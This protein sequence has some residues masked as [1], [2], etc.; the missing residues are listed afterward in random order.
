[1]RGAGLVLAI[2]AI[3]SISLLSACR[4][5]TSPNQNDAANWSEK[6][7][8]TSPNG[9]FDAILMVHL[10]GPPAGG[11]SD[12]NV[13]IVQRGASVG[14][15]EGRE[16]FSADPMT[17]GQLVWKRDHVLEIHYDLAQIHRFRNLWG[18]HE[19]RNVGSAKDDY[20]IE[21]RLMPASDSSV[22]MPDGSFRDR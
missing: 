15:K 12:S 21:I 2:S 11:G 18:L 3:I 22:L 16:V 7:R 9:Q 4:N 13:Y 6:I 17:G 5:R 8:V 19:V 20:E 14:T 10:Y 1:M